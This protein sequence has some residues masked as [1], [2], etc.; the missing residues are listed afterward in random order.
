MSIESILS[1]LAYIDKYRTIDSYDPYDY[2]KRF[3]SAK[4]E[5][6]MLA[7]IRA[8]LAA[9][10]IGKS[11]LG[12]N[13]TSYH[14]TGQYPDWWVGI[15]YNHPINAMCG[16]KTND[17]TRDVVQRELFGVPTDPDSFGSGSI[18]KDAIISTTRKP[19]V[20]NALDS[21]LIRHTSGGVSNV[22][23]RAYE[24]GKEK[25]MGHRLDWGWMDEEPPYD[26]YSQ[27]IRSTISTGG[28]LA[29][30]FTPESGVTEVVDIFMNN[31]PKGA[32]FMNATWAD[33]DPAKNNG[34]GH[35][36]EKEQ[37][38]LLAL[39][40]PYEREMRSKGLP[41]MG[42][43]LI[44]DFPDE[45]ISCPAR[46]IPDHWRRICGFDFGWDHPLGA[47]WIAF[48]PS[49]NDTGYIYHA[50]K[51]SNMK[52]PMVCDMLINAHC[53]WIP[54]AWP[55]DGM[56]CEKDSGK[57]IAHVYSEKGV[58]MLR[59]HFTNPPAK[60]D[61]EGSGGN[62]VEPGIE[63][64]YTAFTTGR[65]KVFNHLTE[66][67]EEKRFYHRK[68]DDSGRSNIVKIK[69]DLMAATRYGW[70]SRRF[71]VNNRPVYN[72]FTHQEGARAW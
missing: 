25:H 29:L 66:W 24:Q 38:R 7:K 6:G 21:A 64:L 9:N 4:D 12:G 51:E 1:E 15:R 65:L 58:N 28:N 55:H 48:D 11:T 8:I 36:D 17:L 27:Y 46:E 53:D 62:A 63:S 32:Y 22:M 10:Q 61:K 41:V 54:V 39:M 35:L 31:T 18:P 5:T 40:Q 50:H 71:A 19:G 23:F 16:T 52:T 42:S 70:Q 72:I 47:V 14:L 26:V 33:A 49:A 56:H 68:A 67:F 20:P 57:P 43:G 13:E 44:F 34:K 30:T 45:A 3:H 60:G 69:D 2:Q 37:E 59:N